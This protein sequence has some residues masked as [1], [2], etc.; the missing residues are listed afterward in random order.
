MSHEITILKQNI[1]FIINNKSIHFTQYNKYITE[2]LFNFR[3]IFYDE[4]TGHAKQEGEIYK[5]PKL[6]ETLKIVAKEGADALYNG[7]LTSK[8]IEDLKKVN[9]IMSEKDL[10]DYK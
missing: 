5:L 9:G 8:F 6:A 2:G 10:A 7:S 1:Y 3:E 4:N